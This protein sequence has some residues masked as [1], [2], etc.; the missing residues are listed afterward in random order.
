[1]EKETNIKTQEIILKNK[2]ML[3]I[4]GTNKIISLKP[5]LIQLD[6]NYG[7]IMIVGEKLE[8]INLDSNSTIA[9]I[10]GDINSIKFVS[11]NKKENVFRKLFKW[12][13]LH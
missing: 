7:G 4:S 10:N 8:L 13:S 9:N 12:F 5:E 3:S 11:T 6:T 1:M 2:S